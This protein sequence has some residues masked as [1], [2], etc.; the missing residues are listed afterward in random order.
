MTVEKTGVSDRLQLRLNQLGEGLGTAYERYALNRFLSEMAERLNI[1]S[2]LE[3]PANGVMGVPGIKSIILSLSGVSVTLANPRKEIL[4]DAGR[5]WDA[6][7]LK[8]RLVACEVDAAPFREDSFDLVWNFC[9]FEHFADTS[10]VVC[11]MKRCSKMFILIEVQNIFNIGFMLHSL[12]HKIRGELWDHGERKAMD[13]RKVV[14]EY[15]LCG[16]GVLE[17]DGNDMP[18]WPDIN[19]RVGELFKESK[20]AGK[21]IKDSFRPNVETKSADEVV[22]LWSKPPKENQYSARMFFIRLWHDFVEGLTPRRVR[23][24]LCHHPYVVG[25]K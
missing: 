10:K 16:I 2:V 6:L 9:C 19:M 23:V 3:F 15:R 20:E 18:P 22:S 1:T 17:L 12:Y 5:I 8:P 4:Q 14:E 13:W 7:G 21:N 25:L 11:E 24:F